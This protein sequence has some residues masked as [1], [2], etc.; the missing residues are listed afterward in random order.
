[1]LGDVNK[2]FVFKGLSTMPSNILPLHLNEI[3]VTIIWIFTE[4]EGDGMESRLPFKIFS[5][6]LTYL[7]ECFL[8][9]F[10]YC[11]PENQL[12][13]TNTKIVQ[14]TKILL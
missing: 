12:K 6:L 7:F 8:I 9:L 14:N 5:I 1:M 2:L 11:Q 10:N 13:I 3:F 4:A